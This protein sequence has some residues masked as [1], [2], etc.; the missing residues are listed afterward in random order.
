MLPD[1]DACLVIGTLLDSL[2]T[3]MCL[4]DPDEQIVTWNAT[5]ERFFPEHR[6]LL[7]RGQP[8]IDNLRQ[9]FRANLLTDELPRLETHVQASIDR[10]RAM[11]APSTFQKKDGRWLLSQA[12]WF[13]D[14]SLLKI[15]TDVTELHQRRVSRAGLADALPPLDFG[16]ATFDA[17]G[18]FVMAN[19]KFN[20]F[21]PATIELCHAG[22]LYA[23]LLER[24]AAQHLEDES[25][26]QLT[27]LAA[28]S[29][30][31]AALL[32]EPLVIKTNIGRWLKLEER[33]TFEG[34]I[35]CVWFDISVEMQAVELRKLATA[36]QQARD[37]AIAERRRAELAD[38][39]KSTFLAR[40]SHELRT[41]MSG[42]IGM[43]ELLLA[44]PLN[45]LQR[46]DVATLKSSATTL[47]RQLDDILDV[48]A[49]EA[50]RLELESVDFTLRGLVNE[51]ADLLASVAAAKRLDIRVEIAPDTP[52][53]VRTDAMRLRQ[54]LYNLVGNGIKFAALGSVTLR[55]SGRAEPD[56]GARLRFEV[57]DTGIG[58][59]PEQQ[60]RLFS[61]STPADSSITRHY[62]GSGLGLVI[63]KYLVERMGGE[64]GVRSTP[65]FGSTF[66]FTLRLEPTQAAAPLTDA[67]TD[68]DAPALRLLV[69]E[70]HP[71]NQVLISRMLEAMGHQVDV[72]ENGSRALE[73]LQ[74]AAYD[75]VLMDIHMPGMGGVEA[76]RR[77]RQLGGAFATLPIIAVT[78]DAIADHREQYM[79]CGLTD[80]L[81][82]PINWDQLAAALARVDG[83]EAAPATGIEPADPAPPD[84]GLI[85]RMMLK[86]LIEA[87]DI[88]GLRQVI[89]GFP[90]R[91]EQGLAMMRG[92]LTAD[93]RAALE[94]QA[95]SLRGAAANLGAARLAACLRP[96]ELAARRGE[97]TMAQI[98]ALERLAQ[99]TL[100][101]FRQ[102]QLLEADG[103]A[104]FTI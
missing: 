101:A 86:A 104:D 90:A 74:R 39:A 59:P 98:D 29:A 3:A 8:Y 1:A 12:H 6:G 57:E 54:I 88:E 40:M 92:A 62:D 102:L 58:I 5:Y 64:I 60:Q 50:G 93:D 45:D 15:W 35:N 89:A 100:A 68:R 97:S 18:R 55:V 41:P 48:S 17:A 7:H 61:P 46:R 99:Q 23:A 66:W 78:A 75:A 63:C 70:D 67:S 37:E 32:R 103:A 44:T 14:G 51:V 81:T 11:T 26:R 49:L 53:T 71:V 43:A 9:F 24:I 2:N 36:M 56:G 22:S 79:T 47:L 91:L 80:F 82:K 87:L 69:A 21:F 31:H 19:R 65:G 72:V 30:P 10:H 13:D 85:D 42:V 34:G 28:R 27:V 4:L 84:D 76:T 83:T 52:A 38:Q 73:A 20:E 25:A 96:L 16:F 33:P 77:I 94:Q 95:H